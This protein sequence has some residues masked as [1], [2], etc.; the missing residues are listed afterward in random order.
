M[1]RRRWEVPQR[2]LL[3]A[4]GRLSERSVEFPCIVPE[5]GPCWV[6][7]RIARKVGGV[8]YCGYPQL[9]V[10]GYRA[11]LTHW[12]SWVSIYGP[13]DDLN[14]ELDHLCH[15]K[16]CWNYGHLDLVTRAINQRRVGGMA[17]IESRR[18]FQLTAASTDR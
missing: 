17:D 16:P 11:P 13:V 15:A 6:P 5:L 8:A 2:D 4:L 14:L 1:N 7:L 12:A 9:Y 18:S 10:R 3:L